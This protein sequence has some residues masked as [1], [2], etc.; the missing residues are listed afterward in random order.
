MT[1]EGTAGR[2]RGAAGG[3]AHAHRA[4]EWEGGAGGRRLDARTRALRAAQVAA[5]HVRDRVGALR[6]AQA[7]RRVA[8]APGEGVGV[9]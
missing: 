5:A 2:T 3:G 1:A 6:R 7:A 9:H 4:A 8:A